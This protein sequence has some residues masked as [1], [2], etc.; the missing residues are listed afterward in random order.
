MLKKIKEKKNLWGWTKEE[1]K[2][3]RN[4]VKLKGRQKEK[5]SEKTYKWKIE[6]KGIIPGTFSWEELCWNNQ[7]KV[8]LSENFFSQ[9]HPEK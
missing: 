5:N 2:G 3:E 9:M 7:D 4:Q 1:K 6:L 8:F